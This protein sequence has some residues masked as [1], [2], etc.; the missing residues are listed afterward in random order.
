[1]TGTRSVPLGGVWVT[2]GELSPLATC[3]LTFGPLLGAL[4]EN[5]ENSGRKSLA[6]ESS[7]LGPGFG[8]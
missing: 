5:Y 7:S 3:I 8:F 6:G 4:W 2:E 1:M